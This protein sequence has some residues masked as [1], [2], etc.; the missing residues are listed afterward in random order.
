MSRDFRGYTNK[1][2]KHISIFGEV[3]DN[4]F[5]GG[6]KLF[7]KEDMSNNELLQYRKIDSKY[8]SFKNRAI[9]ELTSY[10]YNLIVGG[11]G[12]D[13]WIDYNYSK[14]ENFFFVKSIC[15]S[16]VDKGITI[17]LGVHLVDITKYD[18]LQWKEMLCECGFED[19]FDSNHIMTIHPGANKLRYTYFLNIDKVP[20]YLECEKSSKINTDGF[21]EI[22]SMEELKEKILDNSKENIGVIWMEVSAGDNDGPSGEKLLGGRENYGVD[23]PVGIR[24]LDLTTPGGSWIQESWL[25]DYPVKYCKILKNSF[26]LNIY[27]GNVQSDKEYIKCIEK[28]KKKFE[29]NLEEFIYLKRINDDLQE[30]P[31]EWTENKNQAYPFLSYRINLKDI[32]L[33]FN[34][35]DN[36]HDIPK[37]NNHKGFCIYT[38]CDVE[39]ERDILELFYFTNSEKAFSTTENQKVIIFNTEHLMWK[40]TSE[41]VE[42]FGMVVPQHYE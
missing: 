34:K 31:L 23:F 24:G 20:I 15:Q 5:D 35:V 40:F 29:I 26:P 37:L 27:I 1:H 12:F 22:K 21:V 32:V 7:Y 33:H 11:I 18:P 39:W 17:P 16:I 9:Q 19:T 2:K 25:L 30:V 6:F 28:I 41:F 36:V 42:N 8:S 4:Y 14:D 38:D 3:E 13:G 10:V